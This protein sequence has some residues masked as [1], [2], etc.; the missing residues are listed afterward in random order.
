MAELLSQLMLHEKISPEGK[1]EFITR[2]A[3]V[4]CAILKAWP[5]VIALNAPRRAVLTDMG[6][7]M[8]V[9]TLASFSR[10][11][12]AA[13]EGR[14]ANA[15]QELL[16]SR[17]ARN[18]PQR[19]AVLAEQM[20]NGIWS[21]GTSDQCAP[22]PTPEQPDTPVPITPVPEE[23]EV[24]G[25]GL[26]SNANFKKF[27]AQLK[28]HEG[29]RR[30]AYL[31]T[32]TPPILTIGVGH[33]CIARPV[34]G[35]SK[36]GDTIDMETVDALLAEDVREAALELRERCPWILQLC[37]ERRA[38]LWNMAFNLGVPGLMR[39]VNT[40]KAVREG[41]YE[42]AARGMAASLWYKQVKG[43][44]EELVAQMQTG[45]WKT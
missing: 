11:L 20:N 33:N 14:F 25:H 8:G 16:Q 44:G 35:V 9:D 19:S 3:H 18:N 31:D 32:A 27:F 15:S 42:D 41:R 36:V 22:K 7:A 38:V 12:Q 2:L 29:V 5:W 39:F 21:W 17:W 43:R 6:C 26:L 37:E 40:L 30:A 34:R 13:R 28:R 4:E 10:M 24:H 45:K 1:D 23:P